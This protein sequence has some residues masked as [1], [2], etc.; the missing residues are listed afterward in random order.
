MAEQENAV[1]NQRAIDAALDYTP[2]N[3]CGYSC[4][5][6]DTEK[7]S[8]NHLLACGRRAVMGPVLEYLFVAI[9]FATVPTFCF[10]YGSWE[11][12]S[13]DLS[14]VC[15]IIP[16]VMWVILM[17]ALI[18]AATTDP[19]IIPKNKSPPQGST[20][21]KLTIVVDG[22]QKKW[23]RTCF[24][25]RPP[26]AKHCPICDSCV[27]KFDH[28]CPWVG[29]CIA[30]RNYRFFLLFVTTT[31]IH[32]LYVFIFSVIHIT[33][34]ADKNSDGL[35]G[36]MRDEWG[37]MTGL[38]LG[39]MALLPVG[40]LCGYH[41]YLVSINQTTNEEVNDLFKKNK[42]PFNRGQ[43]YNCFEAWCAPQ[44]IS[45]LLP[46]EVISAKM[47]REENGDNL[48]ECKAVLGQT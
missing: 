5:P 17:Y 36:A 40:G 44:R 38:V 12:F 34:S 14:V 46:D 33:K 11:L 10:V 39:F 31:F 16:I 18:S 6:V 32:A 3:G 22:V 30:R 4:V 43:R 15:S 37:T 45:K 13:E 28:H 26:R 25:Y 47:G 23:C 48:E 7:H 27:E 42:N 1:H 2:P 24:I 41:Y 8:G 29:T 9:A 21:L 20:P 19:G 35:M